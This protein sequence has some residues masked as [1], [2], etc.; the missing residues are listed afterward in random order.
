MKL[1]FGKYFG[2]LAIFDLWDRTLLKFKDLNYDKN[3]ANRQLVGSMI[4]DHLFTFLMVSTQFLLLPPPHL[5][6]MNCK[7]FDRQNWSFFAL[8]HLF[9]RD[10]QSSLKLPCP[11]FFSF[12]CFGLFVTFS[13]II[14]LFFHLLCFWFV[15]TSC[16][17][18]VPFFLSHVFGLFETSLFVPF[19]CFGLFV[20]SCFCR[21]TSFFASARVFSQQQWSTFRRRHFLRNFFAVYNS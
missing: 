8:N 5:L 6:I 19:S 21:S 15:F 17:L 20:T 1:C 3:N 16:F 11:V 7:G 14:V 2:Y 18:V 12:S 4:I 9:V 13:F 10:C